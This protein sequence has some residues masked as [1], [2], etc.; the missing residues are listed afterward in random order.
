MQT[1][2][3]REE[4]WQIVAAIPAGNV[5]TYGQVARLAGYPSHARYV[6]TTL[7]NLPKV[8]K[9]PWY[10]VVNGKGQLSFPVNSSAWHRQK[11]CLEA[12][13]VVFIGERFSLAAFRWDA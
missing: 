8:T 13:G 9:L 12:E 6:G 4:I 7:K 10:R 11:S 3:L 5:A 1:S 2:S